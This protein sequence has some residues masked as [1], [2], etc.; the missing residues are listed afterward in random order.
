MPLNVHVLTALADEPKS[1]VELRRAAGSPPQTTMRGRLREL[2]ELG[3]VER[4]QRNGFPGNLDY[5]LG[6]AGRELQPVARILD[7]W[8]AQAP[9]GPLEPGGPAAKS[10]IKALVEGWSTTI[11]RALAARP[12]SLTELDRLITSLSYPSLERRLGAMRLAGQIEACPGCGRGTPYAVTDWLRMGIAPLA[13]A[14]RWERKHMPAEATPISRL[15][16]EAAFLMTVP[17]LIIPSHLS[18]ICRLAVEVQSGAE[19]RL[20]GVMADTRDG[21]V[22]SC[23][24]RLQGH[25]D[26]SVTGSAAAWLRAAIEGDTDHLE[27]GG[28][29]QLA[30]TMIDGLH[31]ALFQ[32][33]QRP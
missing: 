33:M 32:A 4:I 9:E 18:G 22:I 21:R 2:T 13:A 30:A 8:L 12:L 3:V 27:V 11:I 5:E 28:D 24:S 17:I 20:A 25:A 15:D 29:A 14:A 1:L 23:A 16:I 10:A 31:G 7:A 26:A 6:P 19:H